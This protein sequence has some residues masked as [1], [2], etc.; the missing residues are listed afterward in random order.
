MQT[1]VHELNF[2]LPSLVQSRVQLFAKLKLPEWEK[3]WK[4]I[5]G[6]SAMDSKLFMKRKKIPGVSNLFM[7][8]QKY[9]AFQTCL[10][11]VQKFQEGPE[12]EKLR[13]LRYFPHT[14]NFVLNLVK[15]NQIWILI[16][17]FWLITIQILY[18]FGL[19]S[20]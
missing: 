16:K 13:Q 2:T 17:L 4:K 18:G 20:Y 3:K 1:Q 19:S 8:L 5:P 15:S 6:V 14:E 12:W 11:N 7:K 10:W 9:Q